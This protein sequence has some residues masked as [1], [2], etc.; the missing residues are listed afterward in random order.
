L[1]VRLFDFTGRLVS[2]GERFHRMLREETLVAWL[3]PGLRPEVNRRVY[4]LQTAYRPGGFHFERG[5]FDW[6]E[7]LMSASPFPEQGRLL[8]GGAGAGR[9]LAP[10][11]RRGFQ[12]VAFEPAP[13]L[14]AAARAV[15]RDYP[16]AAVVQ[17]S[18]EDLVD[19]VARG[20]G[21]LVGAVR[22]HAFDAVILG[23]GSFS[24]VLDPARQ[25]RL[26]EASR[27]LS[28]SGPL[29][30]SYFAASAEG[31]R[32]ER[33]RVRLRRLLATTG[34]RNAGDAGRVRFLESSGFVCFH[35]RE[36]I[37]H[38]AS[39][40]GYRIALFGSSALDY[41]LLVPR[42]AAPVGTAP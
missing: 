9:E 34:A 36:E 2:A 3:D 29:L 35:T 15:A 38:L 11:C 17:A 20:S 31:G 30:L 41:A 21:P 1:W 18:Y 25:K 5:L 40:A 7:K 4:E 6:E 32:L 42:E 10:L 24:H 23:W 28:P 26:L 37:A 39:D 14:A 13:E 27:Q 22:G 19:A 16:G 33:L 8:L 12:I